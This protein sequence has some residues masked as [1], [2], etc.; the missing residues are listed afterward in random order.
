MH[1]SIAVAVSML[2]L[3]TGLAIAEEPVR[4]VPLAEAVPMPRP[5]E[6]EVSRLRVVAIGAGAV[7]GVIAANFVSGGMVTPI[8]AGVSFAM[9][10]DAAAAAPAVAAAPGAVASVAAPVVSATTAT[11][12]AVHVGI[13]VVGGAIGAAVGNWLYGTYGYGSH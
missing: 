4:M 2:I 6:V 12:A 7:L 13:V 11:M 10:A 3:M 8:L 9:P 1:R 5:A